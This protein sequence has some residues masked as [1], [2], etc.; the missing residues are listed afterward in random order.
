MAAR[1][2]TGPLSWNG[3]DEALPDGI[4]QAIEQIFTQHRSHAPVSALRPQARPA[5]AGQPSP[6]GHDICHG[7]D[8]TVCLRQ[9]HRAGLA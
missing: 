5:G 4:D 9:E 2:L 7:L 3:Q 1:G 8:I 6:A